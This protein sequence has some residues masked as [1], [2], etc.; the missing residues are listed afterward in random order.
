MNTESFR[1]TPVL[2]RARTLLGEIIQLRQQLEAASGDSRY[3]GR[4]SPGPSVEE[5]RRRLLERVEQQTRPD[6]APRGSL[7]ERRLEE[8]RYVLATFADELLV[9]APWYGREAWR[10]N[11][12]EDALFDTHDAGDRVFD[13]VERLL[14][15]KD[16]A[17][18]EV[19][20]VYLMALSL[21]F[22]GRYRGI[23]AGTHLQQVQR[24]L[25]MLIAQ[26][27][28]EPDAPTRHLLD[29]AYA[30]TLTERTD[31]RLPLS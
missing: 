29:Q 11:L 26:R 9:M 27:P 4:S 31:R 16:S 20:A 6:G 3:V 15:E 1:L 7:E 21:G 22:E 2:D 28:P 19:A 18:A 17:R 5:L 12:L 30:H 23:G 14:R 25:F 10:E 24:E 8:I 13:N